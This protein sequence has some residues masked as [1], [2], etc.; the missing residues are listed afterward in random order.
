MTKKPSKEELF[1]N[2][3]LELRRGALTLAVLSQL[4]VDQY[5]YSLK[6]ILSKKG[7]EINE[8]TLYPLL[9]RLEDQGILKSNWEVVDGKR[10]R[11]YYRLSEV[12]EVILASLSAEWRSQVEVVNRLLGVKKER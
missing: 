3:S 2:L 6:Q 7:L 12:G 4:D 8:G 5:G 10:P 9:R 1:E 11:R